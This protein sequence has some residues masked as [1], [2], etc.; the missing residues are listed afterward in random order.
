MSKRALVEDVWP[1][2]NRTLQESAEYEEDFVAM[3]QKA[4]KA[5]FDA[6]K[7]SGAE[8][9]YFGS[10]FW[11]SSFSAGNGGFQ[12]SVGGQY[13]PGSDMYQ[14]SI[15]ALVPMGGYKRDY[16]MAIDELQ[17]ALRAQGNAFR[18]YGKLQYFGEMDRATKLWL[19]LR[20]DQV[21][22]FMKDAPRLTPKVGKAFGEILKDL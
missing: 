1:H 9:R 6:L 19:E 2:G 12:I 11:A 14:F 22:K 21:E 10:D 15:S 4:G 3:H 7:K 17:R 16:A 13:A 8:A 20:P 5:L 18:K